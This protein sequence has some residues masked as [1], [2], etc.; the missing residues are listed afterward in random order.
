MIGKNLLKARLRADITQKDLAYMVGQD[1]SAISKWE[2]DRRVI[3]LDNLILLCKVL[4][5]SADKLLGIKK[6][7]R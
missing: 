3:T 4:N 6:V 1:V 2:N 5:V 7:E